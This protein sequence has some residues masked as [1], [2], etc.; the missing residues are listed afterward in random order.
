M[1]ANHSYHKLMKDGHM[2]FSQLRC[3]VALAETGSFTEAAYTVGMTQSAVSHAL[4]HLERELGVTLLERNRKGVVAL[5]DVGQKIIP[6][7][8]LLLTQAES[9]EQ[10]AKAVR[11]LTMGKLRLGSIFSLCPGLLTG[12]LTHFQQVYPDIEVILFEGTLQ[13]VQEW[14]ATGI[15]DIGFVFH[16]AKKV[17]S[18]PIAADALHVFVSE[19]HH[20][21]T[22]A[23]VTVNDLRK[24]RLIMPK[25]GSAFLEMVSFDLKATGSSI[26]YQA[27]DGATILAMVREGLGVTLLPQMMLPQ[28]L[29][30]VVALPLDPPQQVQI[31]LATQAKGMASPG[32]RLF[33]QTAL[34]WTQESALLR[35]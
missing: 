32:V 34:S 19:G 1:N 2:N 22:Q 3:V 28:M 29:E 9:I 11:G 12:V 21:H 20:L 26:R 17:K 30:G 8:R 4:A 15:I 10:E 35:S 6:H 33:V 24:E 23:T 13:E 16:E 14:I 25:T 18:T 5:T 31:G 7:V 27:S